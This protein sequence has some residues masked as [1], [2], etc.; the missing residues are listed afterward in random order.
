MVVEQRVAEDD[1]VSR[2]VAVS[3]QTGPLEENP[4]AVTIAVAMVALRVGTGLA[5]RVQVA[6]EAG[7]AI[8]RP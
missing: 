5:R 1:L 2:P 7:R 8:F 3:R 4:D 6:L